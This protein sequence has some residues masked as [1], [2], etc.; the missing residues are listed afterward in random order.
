[1]P[2]GC[3]IS[4]PAERSLVQVLRFGA[5]LLVPRTAAGLT[6]HGDDY[7]IRLDDGGEL[8]ARTVIIAAGVSYRQPDAAGLDRFEGT[9]AQPDRRLGASFRG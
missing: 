4:R 8:A 9:A 2:G 3:G 1:M 6:G 7:V 5:T